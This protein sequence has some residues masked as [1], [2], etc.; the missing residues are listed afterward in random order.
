MLA[1][2]VQLLHDAVRAA[3]ATDAT[4]AGGSEQGE[5][6]LSPARLFA[7]LVAADGTGERC[8]V[9]DGSE[10][11]LLER[12]APPAIIA[13]GPDET[14]HNVLRDR[15]VVLDATKKHQQTQNYPA[16]TASLVRPGCR[17]HPRRPTLTYVY[18]S[19]DLPKT[20]VNA[21]RLRAARVG[22][23][24]CADSPARVRVHTDYT[25][26]ADAYRWDAGKGTTPLPVPYDGY[27]D[28]LDAGFD[29][30]QSGGVVRRSW[31]PTEHESYGDPRDSAPERSGE[32]LVVALEHPVRGQALLP[33]TEALRRALL[34]VLGDDAPS[35]AHGHGM[36]GQGHLQVR[37]LG[38]PFVGREHA[39]GTIR[40]VG[41]WLPPDIADADVRA[42]RSALL[43]LRELRSR[44]FG[45]RACWPAYGASLPWAARQER[46]FGPRR[47]AS[48]W[49][50]A[51]PV[52]HER[53]GPADVDE[54][55]RWF[56]HAGHPA[57]SEVRLM[58]GPFAVGGLQLKPSDLRPRY[59]EHR[60]SHLEVRFDAPVA[61]PLV[62]GRG[63]QFG[64]GLLVPAQSR[65]Q[66][67]PR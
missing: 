55:R 8:R 29:R 27:L 9:T 46:W 36:D 45:V 32:L 59:A 50:S 22:Y 65:S 24:G 48:V 6:P 57:P 44:A 56:Q 13:D 14:L 3:P 5:W 63:R 2:E 38:L 61:G 43:E 4:L 12:A 15:F 17:V 16:R 7:A 11:L 41:L 52:I 1:I 23:V 54:V 42:I 58:R 51:T 26:P 20:A 35:V 60:F 66:A 25:V 67:G 64:L 40:A 53:H 30:M 49:Q 21:L 62:V 47:G 19:L 33:L 10:L 39:D 37:Y 34:S 18:D 28:A 31:I